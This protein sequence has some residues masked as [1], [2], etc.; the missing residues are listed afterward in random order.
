[1]ARTGRSRSRS[2]GVSQDTLPEVVLVPALYCSVVVIDFGGHQGFQ[3]LSFFQV[4]PQLLFL[5][6]HLV[7]PFP[8]INTAVLG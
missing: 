4:R 1:M 8:S 2:P 3:L 7:H 6:G 5:P